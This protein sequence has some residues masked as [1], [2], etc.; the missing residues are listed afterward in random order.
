VLLGGLGLGFTAARLLAAGVDHLDV[1]EIEQCLIGWA[2]AGLTPT[3]ASVARHPTAALHA[4]DIRAV[5]AGVQPAPTGPWNAIVLD[6]DNGPDFL[7]N[8]GNAVLYTAP[9][10]AAAYA[11]LAPG[12]T[13]AIWC[14]GPAPGL[15]AELGRISPSATPHSFGRVRDGRSLTYVSYTVT[16]V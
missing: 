4:G 10:L 5:L 14:Q 9:S 8:E 16:K 1:V 12:G 6:V 7:I 15:M 3:L 13:M 11:H 2:Y